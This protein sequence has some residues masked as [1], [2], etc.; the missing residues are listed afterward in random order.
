[1]AEVKDALATGLTAFAGLVFLVWI[2][3][4]FVCRKGSFPEDYPPRK[5]A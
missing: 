3:P 1:M 2:L 5:Q 4:G